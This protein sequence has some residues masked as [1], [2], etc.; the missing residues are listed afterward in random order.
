MPAKVVPK[1]SVVAA[2]AVPPKRAAAPTTAATT[3]S[4]SAP[5]AP[6]TA[7]V[8]PAPPKTSR[9]PRTKVESSKERP[10]KIAAKLGMDAQVS[11]CLGT[12]KE[13]LNRD[14]LRHLAEVQGVYQAVLA[15]R[16]ALVK[17]KAAIKKEGGDVTEATAKIKEF[18]DSPEF[19]VASSAVK[20]VKGQMMRINHRAGLLVALSVDRLV[21]E[22]LGFVANMNC[23]KLGKE[24]VVEEISKRKDELLFYHL[25][26]SLLP[27]ANEK[28]A[29]WSRVRQE[30]VTQQAIEA[31]VPADAPAD[32]EAPPAGSRK[33]KA[34]LPKGPFHAL[35]TSKFKKLRTGEAAKLSLGSEA[36]EFVS[37]LMEGYLRSLGSL[38]SLLRG[39]AIK[40][41]T[42]TQDH[43]Y[44]V[45][46]L[47]FHGAGDADL[48]RY[49]RVEQLL[50]ESINPH[51]QEDDAK[52][53]VLKDKRALERAEKK[54]SK[55]VPEA[56]APQ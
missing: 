8:A 56:S 14:H 21:G 18:T 4:V 47:R 46:R 44:L 38:I 12:V 20:A 22:L 40:T 37:L 51:F 6:T 53:Q 7:P 27:E 54:A 16:D 30:Q 41:K 11:K 36:K 45:L 10:P 32:G 55:V 19:K 1:R 49:Q 39:Q 5:A 24:Q 13:L 23:N 9:A 48:S 31:E 15:Q 3:A 17:E 42:I 35:V 26:V 29:E 43:I 33:K 50:S 28:L 52:R 25:L 34:P 2:A